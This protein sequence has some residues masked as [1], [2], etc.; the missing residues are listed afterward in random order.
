MGKELLFKALRGEKTER[1][2]WV[3]FVGCHGAALVDTDAETY[4]KSGRLMAQGILAAIK[5]Y[6]PDGIP[7]AF[8]LSIEAEVLGCELVWAQE[9]PPAVTGHLLEGDIMQFPAFDPGA[10]RIPCIVE[11]IKIAKQSIKNTALY[12]LVTGPFTLALH[13]R[14]TRIFMDMFDD[15]V[16]VKKLVEY[17]NE[18]GK[19]MADIYMNAGCDV[20]SL[21]DPMTSQIS[22]DAFRE[23]V[24]PWAKDFFQHV[25]KYNTLTSFF[26]CGHAQKN[27]QAMC[28]T[29]PHNISV[30][31]NIP[32]DYVKNICRENGVSFGGNLQL[33]VILLMGSADDVRRNVMECLT[34]G[35]DAGFV[36]APGCDL[37]YAV[38][39]EHLEL[40]GRM[41]RDP[42]QQQVAREL[43][44]KKT[45]VKA[46]M[47]MS[48][49][50]FSDKVIVDVITLDSESCAPCQ[51]MVEA[52][53]AVTPHFGDLVVWREHAIKKR[54]AVEF[55]MSLMV[56][57][58]PTICIDGMIKFVSTIPSRDELIRA[59]QERINE[60][61]SL[62]L[63]EHQ[64]RL[65]VFGAGD[66]KGTQTWQNVQQAALELGSTVETVL[67]TGVDE[68]QRYGVA[69]RPAV[70]AINE[71]VK[72]TG[73]V[74]TVDVIKEWLKALE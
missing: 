15:P 19:Q 72:I 62:K 59:I 14:G 3:P 37:P 67:L 51:Y 1:A 49:Y 65:L 33:T 18:I 74:P 2:P 42:Y 5:R 10:G 44:R 71:Q 22:P 46:G 69:V 11:A 25:K 7:A 60:K 24:T 27:V 9:N 68:M 47:N 73:R 66:E 4:L 70:V 35:G 6:Q 56:K 39:P 52:V 29:G 23:F 45:D 16:S 30:D 43:L 53:K 40:V 55:M 50:G 34:T 58:V 41:V 26:V 21:V 31:E 64:G 36:L 20:I 61:F 32:L 28:E 48:D 17:C 57:N 38:P 12:G 54:E 8:D 63:R 13:L